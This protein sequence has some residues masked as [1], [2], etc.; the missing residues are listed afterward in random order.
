M[1]ASQPRAVTS[2]PPRRPSRLSRPS[3]AAALPRHSI[4]FARPTARS[5][6]TVGSFLPGLTAQAFKKFGFSTAHF[7]VDWPTIAGKDLAR[8]SAPERLKWPPRPAPGAGA[9]EAEAEPGRGRR[10][11]TLVL[12]VE[13]AR[14][15]DIQYK[16]QQI[17]ERINA[18]FGYAAVS[19]LRLVQAPLPAPAASVG[20]RRAAPRQTVV[21]EVEGIADGALR[22]A[23]TRLGSHLHAR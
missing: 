21:A 2:Y 14:A 5:L 22:D 12:R 9:G 8:I 17:L 7:I 4:A 23:L 15:L 13:G 3:P 1:R 6:K 18:Y 10:G 16:R 20:R 19:D 11:A